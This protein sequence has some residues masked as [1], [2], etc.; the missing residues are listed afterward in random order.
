VGDFV[1]GLMKLRNPVEEASYIVFTDGVKYYAKNGNTGM[2]EYSGDDAGAVINYAINNLPASGGRIFIRTGTYSVK[3]QIVINKYAVMLEGEQLGYGSVPGA[4]LVLNGDFHMISIAYS[5]FFA[6]I[7]N[8]WLYGNDRS[9]SAIYISSANDV[10]IEHCFIHRFATAFIQVA[11]FLHVLRVVDN[12]IETGAGQGV[13]LGGTSTVETVFIHNNYFYDTLNAV[14]ITNYPSDIFSVVIS[15]NIIRMTKQHAIVVQKGA[16]VII[17][18]NAILDVGYASPNTYDGIRLENVTGVVV[19]G[20]TIINYK[21]SNMKYAVEETGS[22]DYNLI[23]NN[24][25]KSATS[26]AIV[27]IGTNSVSENNIVLP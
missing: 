19:N 23:V 1:S 14:V 21:T 18:G 9:R 13:W 5:A 17:E 12:W 20:N 8:L 26:P 10:T 24:I 27:K 2:I 11:G 4:K 6:Y 3:T 25:V 16:L 22:A 15:N 7:R